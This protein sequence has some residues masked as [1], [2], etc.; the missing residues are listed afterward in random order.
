MILPPFV[1]HHQ[2]PGAVH[3]HQVAFLRRDGLDA[4]EPDDTRVLRLEGGLLGHARRRAAELA[5]HG[6]CRRG[7]PAERSASSA[8]C[9]ARRST[10]PR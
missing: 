10:A 3:H 5:P 7:D 4:V 1:L 9:P 8:A 2:R 6:G